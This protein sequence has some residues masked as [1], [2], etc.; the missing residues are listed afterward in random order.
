M[1]D[2]GLDDL[3]PSQERAR[4][5]QRALRNTT[6]LVVLGVVLVGAGMVA[7][8]WWNP[9]L[10]EATLCPTDRSPAGEHIVVLDATD[11]WNPV[12]ARVVHQEFQRIQQSLP[13]FARLTL[14]TLG[15]E[16]A[17]ARG[18]EP[19][20]PALSLCNPGR[21]DD[22]GAFPVLGRLAGHLLANPHA[23]QERW[24]AEFAQRLD[25]VLE[26]EAQRAGAQTSPIMETV[27]WATLRAEEPAA[28]GVV[29]L[30]SD[31]LQHSDAYSVYRARDWN[32]EAA[33]A[34]ADVG[35]LGTRGLEGYDVEIYFIERGSELAPAHY[36]RGALVAF[37]EAFFAQQGARVTRVRRLEG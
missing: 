19:F 36:R 37:W 15:D 18:A 23:M 24:K 29:Y 33:R 3:S 25:E 17:H 32:V 31:L 14:Y 16:G 5:E 26:A 8:L 34:L 13:R 2:Y 9:T 35:R 28:P 6:I 27:R 10:D 21:P 7:A 22:F 11:A 12:Q 4:R 1:P 30:F 20:A